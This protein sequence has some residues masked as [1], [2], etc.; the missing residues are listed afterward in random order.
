ML[1]INQDHIDYYLELL[2]NILRSDRIVYLHDK[3]NCLFKGKS[4]YPKTWNTYLNLR[5]PRSWTKDS[6]TK[7]FSKK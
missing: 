2:N 4:N 7:I 5:T 6:S 1:L 3:K